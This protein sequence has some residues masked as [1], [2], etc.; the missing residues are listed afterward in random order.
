MDVLSDIQAVSAATRY[1]STPDHPLPAL[2]G[3][4]PPSPGKRGV[5]GGTTT[6]PGG[7]GPKWGQWFRRA[8]RIDT[9]AANPPIGTID[10]DAV[11]PNTEP[12]IDAVIDIAVHRTPGGNYRPAARPGWPIGWFPRG[13]D[14]FWGNYNLKFGKKEP[15]VTLHYQSEVPTSFRPSDGVPELFACDLLPN[16]GSAEIQARADMDSSP[17]PD[18][19][20]QGGVGLFDS[21]GEIS[22]FADVGNAELDG[23]MTFGAP[24]FYGRVHGVSYPRSKNPDGIACYHFRNFLLWPPRLNVTVLGDPTQENF[25]NINWT[26]PTLGDLREGPYPILPFN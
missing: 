9:P 11:D 15:T 2:S 22:G 8:A 26:V 24:N 25:G 3:T 10:V 17:D 21:H 16:P 6:T 4:T 5:Y 7:N 19:P 20:S 23:Q 1:F 14:F 13:T 18:D 12:R